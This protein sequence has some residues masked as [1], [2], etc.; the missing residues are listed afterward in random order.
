MTATVTNDV[1]SLDFASKLDP[2][3]TSNTTVADRMGRDLKRK[4]RAL[5]F[6]HTKRGKRE[7]W[8]SVKL[9]FWTQTAGI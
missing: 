9:S 5:N 8:K 3:F 7:N 1:H 6:C 4:R 2:F